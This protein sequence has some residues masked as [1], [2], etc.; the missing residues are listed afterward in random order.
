[1]SS[2][3]PKASKDVSQSRETTPPE[4]RVEHCTGETPHSLCDDLNEEHL[5]AD[6]LQL[7]V[8]AADAVHSRL[9]SSLNDATGVD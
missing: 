1:M 8:T 4:G 6:S 5:P 9:G 3:E 2:P 7:R